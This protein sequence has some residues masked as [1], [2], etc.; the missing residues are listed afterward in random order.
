MKQSFLFFRLYELIHV[1]HFVAPLFVEAIPLIYK[2]LDQFVR[3]LVLLVRVDSFDPFH[4][5]VPNLVLL[6][7]EAHYAGNEEAQKTR[8]NF[9]QIPLFHHLTGQGVQ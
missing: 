8:Q 6:N 7:F 9:E 2:V 5:H 1:G 3:Q 4:E